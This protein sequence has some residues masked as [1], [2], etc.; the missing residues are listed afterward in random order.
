M[1]RVDQ[2]NRQTGMAV[3]RSLGSAEQL[4]IENATG[5]LLVAVKKAGTPPTRDENIE[6]DVNNRNTSFAVDDATKSNEHPL[7][8][9]AVN[10]LWV[11]Y[12]EE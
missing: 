4:L 5:R 12:N 8:T 11:N 10:Y 1:P 3:S 2:N 6:I 9:D 7:I